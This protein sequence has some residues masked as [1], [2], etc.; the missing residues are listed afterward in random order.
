MTGQLALAA[1]L[2]IAL[3]CAT[4]RFLRIVQREHYLPGALASTLRRWLAR[5]PPNRALAIGLVVAIG[6]CA[7]TGA[8]VAA[9]TVA[10]LA[11]AGIAAVVPWGM[12]L[13]GTPPMR[14]TRRLRL[15]A[16]TAV[17]LMVLLSAVLW[18]VV[19]PTL[20]VASGAL[21]GALAIELALRLTA[22]IERRIARRY[23]RAATTKLR[24]IAPRVVGV[25]GSYGKTT[26]KNHIRDLLAPTTNVF[27]TPASWNNRAG[28]SRAVTEQLAVGTEVFVAEMGT[29]G[30]GEIA[31]LVEWVKPEVAVICGLGPVHLERMGS[32]EAIL[33]AKAEILEGCDQAVLAVGHA[34][35][36]AL[37]DR[38]ASHGHPRWSGRKIWRVGTDADDASLDVVATTEAVGGPDD[39][40]TIRVEGRTSP[41]TA[42]IELGHVEGASLHPSNV[43]CAVAVAL[44]LGA[45]PGEL[46]QPLCGLRPPTSRAEVVR[47]P[48]DLLIIDD[49]FNSN[50]AGA[51]AALATLRREVT[52]GDLVVV[53]PGMVELGN[54][55]AEA[56]AALAEAAVRCGATL[57][58]VGWTNLAALAT[59]AQRGGGAVIRVPNRERAREWVRAHTRPG[60]GVLWENDL[61]DHYP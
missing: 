27:A 52:R 16:A 37:A 44:A 9:R 39:H 29:Y 51:L 6:I 43:A 1:V 12:S 46:R 17:A 32:I 31:D 24:R 60:D 36:R 28:L 18:I 22:P 3:G 30:A 56:N 57:V 4:F 35:V 14:W 54:E 26:T 21:V 49:T 2:A 19:D 41:D 48:D 47:T 8:P 34:L 61:P 10:A 25:T 20:A 58:A 55:Q 59:G 45:D 7:V 33:E 42:R 38:M 15:L 40:V 53:T 5:R 11:G 13:R 50:P 23:V